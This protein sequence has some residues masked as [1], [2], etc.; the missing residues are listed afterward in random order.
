MSFFDIDI[1]IDNNLRKSFVASSQTKVELLK[2]KINKNVENVEFLFKGDILENDKCLNDYSII[3][4][5]IIYCFTLGKSELISY[6]AGTTNTIG[7][8]LDIF[9]QILNQNMNIQQDY[10]EQISTL[11]NMGFY[12]NDQNLLL[13]NLYQGNIEEVMNYLLGY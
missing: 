5:S 13:L 12:D 9:N 2:K 6:N 1:I 7:T 3:H 11:N 10:S 4:E 8:F